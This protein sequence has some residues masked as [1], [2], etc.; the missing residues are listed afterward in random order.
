MRSMDPMGKYAFNDTMA[1]K[2][3]ILLLSPKKSDG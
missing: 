3:I 1:V 2:W